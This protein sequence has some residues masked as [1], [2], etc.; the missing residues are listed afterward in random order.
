MTTGKPEEMDAAKRERLEMAG[1]RFGDVYEFFGLTDEDRAE[2][3]GRLLAQDALLSFEA[4][5]GK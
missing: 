2:I 4:K 1:W 3:E 5:Q